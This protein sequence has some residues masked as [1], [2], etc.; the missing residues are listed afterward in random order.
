MYAV[1]LSLGYII[2]KLNSNY[3]LLDYY[4]FCA[5][6]TAFELIHVYI[7]PA[8]VLFLN[9]LQLVTLP[10]SYDRKSNCIASLC[11]IF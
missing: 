6:Y 10:R 2:L 3:S 8:W 1:C 7:R 9:E 4:P 5:L 11:V